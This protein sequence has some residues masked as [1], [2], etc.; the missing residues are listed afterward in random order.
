MR[1]LILILTIILFVVSDLTGQ[2]KGTVSDD[3]GELLPYVSIYVQNTSTGT[4]TNA[5]GAYHLNLKPGEYTINYR[6]IGYKTETRQIEISD[7]EIEVDI[8]LETQA[9]L[10][11][12]VII[13]ADAE[14][15]AYVII[16]KAIKKREFFKNYFPSYGCDV[17]VKGNQKI[18]NVPKKFMGQEIGDLDGALDSNRQGIV[19]LSESV[20][21]LHVDNEDYKEIVVSS[22]ISGDDRG[23]S[24]NSAREMEFNF[25]ENTI[26]LERQM[27]TPLADNALAYY[28][29]KLEGTFADENGKLINEISVIPKRN[30]DPVFH[31]KIYIVEDE[32]SINSLKLGVTSSAS[33]VYVLD[34][35]TFNQVFIP[36]EESEGYVLF[37]NTI[38]F[39][40]TI[41]GV[42]F[43]GMFGGMYSNYN[44]SPNYK[45]GFF[46]N[47]VHIV[48]E[49]SNERDSAFWDDIR[50]LPLTI[51]EQQDYKKRDSISIARKDPL[52]LDSIDRVNN[53]FGIGNILG[54]YNYQK[55]RKHFYLDISSPLSGIQFNTVQGYN[56]NLSFDGR[57]Y[58]DEDETR[59]ILFGGD[60]SYGF[61]EKK[62]RANG[63]LTYRPSRINRNQFSLSGGSDVLQ[64]NRQEP[65]SNTLNTLYSL[66]LKDNYA[67]YFDLKF[68]KFQYRHEAW[69]GIFI[70]HSLD[71]EER[72]PLSNNSDQSY[73]KKEEAYTSN[74]PLN[75]IGDIPVF[76][77]HQALTYDLSIGIRFNQKYVLF[78]DRK[79][80]GGSTGPLL[81]LGYTGAFNFGGADISFHKIAASLSG[82]WEVGVGGR[83]Q[84][85]VN[86]GT[87]LNNEQTSFAD[88]RHFTGN[89]IF[90]TKS[91]DYQRSFLNLP[92]YVYST[93]ESYAQVHLQH[94]FDGWLL[95]K[96][97]V[98]RSLGWSLVA[99][100]KHLR[101]TGKPS[102]SELHLGLDNIGY[103]FIRLIR[104][105][106]VLS[107]SDSEQQYAVRMSLGF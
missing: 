76:E 69:N 94:H 51:E 20:S 34:S 45:S 100:A 7:Q 70:N 106:G 26:T 2:L 52:Y 79:F 84:W 86:A 12:E 97:P 64:F 17:Y 4:T 32:W 25:Y 107:L 28:K 23:Y 44:M 27:V 71:W 68:V 49:N 31:G 55:Q 102:Y 83:L 16:R 63:Y 85:Y 96:I 30:N 74:D 6:F 101:V 66:F 77:K 35:L 91:P 105:D 3:K 47:Y 29:Y 73:F 61:S 67:K 8:V 59:R 98:L 78:P 65:I 9:T 87:Y 11:S 95:D 5:V 33:K 46:D 89:Q 92:Y 13:A 60:A 56:L 22:K 99:G 18:S 93:D 24:F 15:P 37:S 50:P 10:L 48:E 53:S 82:E 14:D 54:G 42:K 43:Q 19:Y 57:K 75:P 36:V 58:Y 90:F 1:I 62:L 104:I 103:G 38:T 88:Y 81:Q 41:F 21:R 39:G 40:M 80:N 72:S